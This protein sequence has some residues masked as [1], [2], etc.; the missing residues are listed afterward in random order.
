VLAGKWR[1]EDFT[2]QPHWQGPYFGADWGFAHDPSVL[3]K[4]WTADGRL[5]LEHEAG[6]VQL[7]MDDLARCFREIPDATSHTIR[8]DSARPETIN[9]L[10]R[11]GFTI[12]PADKWDGSVKDGVEHLR[13]A[14]ETIVIHP[15]CKRAQQEARLWRY[16]TDKRTGDVLPKLVD[17]DNHVFDAVRYGLGPLIKHAPSFT[18]VRVRMA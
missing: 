4:L 3:V 12:A 8:G 2:P 14:Y 5:Y 11:R 13:G 10:N 7:D 6:G 16:Q 15:R 9:E 1:V 17:R 18:P